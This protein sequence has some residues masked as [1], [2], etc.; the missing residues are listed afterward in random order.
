MPFRADS[1]VD[2]RGHPGA[3]YGLGGLA[4]GQQQAMGAACLI[5]GAAQLFPHRPAIP[6]NVAW[7]DVFEAN[8]S[9]G[10]IQ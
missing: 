5:L 3:L 6:V 8:L 1:A 7:V 10:S 2:L 4:E 9:T